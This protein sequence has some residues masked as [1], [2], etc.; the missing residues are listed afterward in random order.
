[1]SKQKIAVV[2]SGFSGL[3]A[4]C[5]LAKAG[6]KVSVYEKNAEIGGRA[7]MFEKDGFKFDMGPSW[8]WM[9]DVF[10][11][12]F[13]DFGKKVSDYYEL[14]KLSPGF[15][16]IFSENEKVV[17]DSDFS[18]IINT[19]ESIEKGSGNKLI[20]FIQ[21][22]GYK[23]QMSM[24]ELVY[25]P[26][27]HFWEF[28]K[29]D[30]IKQVFKTNLFSP[31]S[32]E[33]R[34]LFRDNKLRQIM[35]FPVIFLGAMADKIP[36]LYSIMNYAALSQGTFYPM[37]GMV[38]IVNAM[39][40]LALSLG[41]EFH[42]QSPVQK[43]LVENN[44]AKGILINDKFEEFDAIISSADYHHTEMNLLDKEYR[45]YDESY[46]KS[47]V[48][49]P[50][51]ILF[52]LGVDKKIPKLEHHNLFFDTDYQVHADAIYTNPNWIKQPLFYV[53]N[54][55]KTDHSVAPVGKENIFILI[56]YAIQLDE[57][58]NII[59]DYYDKVIDRLEAYSGEKIRE[60]VIYKKS[61]SGKNFVSEYNSYRGNAYGL[62]NTLLQTAFLKP[63][64]SN[65]KVKNLMYTGQLTVPGPGVPPSLISGKIVATEMDKYLKN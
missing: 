24:S 29:W 27:H 36:A 12:F 28:V 4:A 35:E 7:R 18:D 17:I 31:L 1:M 42:T 56:P 57:N 55:S 22:A 9:P 40:K 63:K 58:D 64:L 19:F 26:S 39:H 62:A 48:F 2:G 14:K 43:I 54:P 15:Q 37:G 38:E 23:Y 49:A 61:F 5:Y 10:E 45:N 3:S 44:L 21:N 6:Y 13:C 46:W 60:L 59:N 50:S 8:Y 30:I 25:K 52:Y 20:Q 16:V 32:R 53:C 65:R 47:R 41:V 33:V 51:S 11:R 34:K